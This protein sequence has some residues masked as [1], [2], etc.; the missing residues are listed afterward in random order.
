VST[1]RQAPDPVTLA[2]VTTLGV[3]GAPARWATAMTEADLV[4]CVADAD[5]RAEPV[6]L[7]GGGSNLLVGDAGFDGVAV[8]I[9]T[10]GLVAA[11]DA[12][13]GEEVAVAAGESWDDLVARAA[14]SGWIGIEALSGIPGQV[15]ATPIQNVGAYGQEVSDTVARVRTY[16]RR[17]GEVRTF[18]AADCGFGYR[19]SRFKAEPD[20]Y[21]V[22]EVVFQFRHG[23]LGTPIRYAE[24]AT[25]LQ[26]SSGERRP[27]TEVRDAV[28]ALRRRK[29]MVVGPADPDTRSAGSF[30]TNPILT[31]AAA[32]RLPAAAPRFP[33]AGGQ[34]KTSA[35]WLIEAAGFRRGHGGAAARLSSKH[36]L[37]LVNAGGATAADL[38]ALAAS[39][40]QA[41]ADRF[42]VLLEPEPRLVG[43]AL[44]PVEASSAP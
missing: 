31:P 9:A 19:T 39:I 37:A 4:A 42:G 23:D 8:R 10:R 6:L 25:A 5:R 18:A 29:G 33:A 24:L 22:L 40:R 17:A 3:G 15:G 43:C 27:V 34:V 35:A 20:R 14:S 1:Q 13:G 30:F 38:I 21:L 26:S 12:C 36:T 32:D 11:G 28:L 7:V 2:D 41:V 44:P 16:D